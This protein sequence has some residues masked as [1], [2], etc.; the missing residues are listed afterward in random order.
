[1][2]RPTLEELFQELEERLRALDER[3]GQ[4]RLENRMLQE[5]I[6]RLEQTQA[7]AREKVNQV[8]DRIDTL[9]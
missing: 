1:M 8:L 3:L 6:R 7:A 5:R 2:A 9:G 4:M